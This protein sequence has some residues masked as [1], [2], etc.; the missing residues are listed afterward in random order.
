MRAQEISR[1]KSS[2]NTPISLPYS[3]KSY[4]MHKTRTSRENDKHLSF[5]RPFLYS[6][7]YNEN[8]GRGAPYF[9]LDTLLFLLLPVFSFSFFHAV[10]ARFFPYFLFFLPAFTGPFSPRFLHL[11]G[12]MDMK[13]TRVSVT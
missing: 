2:H 7:S 5:A 12:F 9:C 13:L 4:L 10:I 11:V 1:I 8:V 6:H 3:I